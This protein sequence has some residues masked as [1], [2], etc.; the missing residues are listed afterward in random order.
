MLGG[1]TMSEIEGLRY[2]ALKYSNIG[3][4]IENRAGNI[5]WHYFYH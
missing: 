1:F 3:L 4:F 5:N 2:L